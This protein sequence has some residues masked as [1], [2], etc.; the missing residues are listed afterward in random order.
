MATPL[1]IFLE[2]QLRTRDS[3]KIDYSRLLDVVSSD[4]SYRLLVNGLFLP[5]M[6]V[7]GDWSDA[8]KNE[9]RAIAGA[10]ELAHNIGHEFGRIMTGRND[11]EVDRYRAV[12]E[13]VE[14]MAPGSL[15]KINCPSETYFLAAFQMDNPFSDKLVLF[16][17]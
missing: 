3:A 10:R 4:S 8:E 15:R 12:Y 17:K 13:E 14:R 2:E 9:I 1:R 7:M 6:G 11:P 16:V 5:S